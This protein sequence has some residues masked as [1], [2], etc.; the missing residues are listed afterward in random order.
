[1]EQT[2]CGHVT[3]NV[4]FSKIAWIRNTAPRRDTGAS[5]EKFGRKFTRNLLRIADTLSS[6]NIFLPC[7]TMFMHSKS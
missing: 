3:L 6:K 1:M 2:H 4:I 5:E 7:D